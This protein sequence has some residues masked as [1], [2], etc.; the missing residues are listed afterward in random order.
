MTDQKLEAICKIA[1]DVYEVLGSGHPEI[2]YDRAMQVGLRLEGF[3]YESQKVIELK[4]RGLYVGEGYPDLIV[5]LDSKKVVV[6]LKAVAAKMG[7][8]EV[9]QVQNYMKILGVEHGLLINFQMPK[10][11]GSELE[12]RPVHLV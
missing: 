11:K 2:V 1:K 7:A 9:R 6:E 5:H 12:I 8:C 4:Y 10:E 3:T